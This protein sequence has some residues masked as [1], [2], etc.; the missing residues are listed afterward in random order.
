MMLNCCCFPSYVQEFET[1]HRN[2]LTTL[3]QL[4]EQ[5]QSLQAKVQCCIAGSVIMLKA[6]PPKLNPVIRPLM[7]N[8]KSQPDPLLQV[9]V[10]KRKPCDAILLR[11]QKFCLS[12]EW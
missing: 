2:L 5:H 9:R 6:L 10:D 3:G 12:Q 7:D 11:W 1:L 4:Q 8:I